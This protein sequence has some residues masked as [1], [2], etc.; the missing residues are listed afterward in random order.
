MF[1]NDA[2]RDVDH[3]MGKLFK[4]FP[5][6]PRGLKRDRREEMC[7]ELRDTKAFAEMCSP[8]KLRKVADGG[9]EDEGGRGKGAEK[10]PVWAACMPK[11]LKKTE[12]EEPPS[13]ENWKQSS[14]E[15]IRSCDEEENRVSVSATVQTTELSCRGKDDQ[16]HHLGGDSWC[17]KCAMGPCVCLLL[18]LEMKIDS[19]KGAKEEDRAGGG[20]ADEDNK[21]PEEGGGVKGLRNLH[22]VL[23]RREKE[24][25]KETPRRRRVTPRR[26][27]TTKYPYHQEIFPCW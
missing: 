14:K 26:K 8:S 22:E 9:S 21:V 20:C 6:K 15:D 1:I 5:V 18:K 13:E 11:N 12:E 17:D 24:R 23:L 4:C 25:S 3:L 19:L 10:Q 27:P 7:E 16:G 2:R